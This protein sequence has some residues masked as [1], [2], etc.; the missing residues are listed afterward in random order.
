MVRGIRGEAVQV[1][2]PGEG[3]LLRGQGR[4]IQ[5]LVGKVEARRIMNGRQ[6]EPRCKELVARF[7]GP[8]PVVVS[9]RRRQV[10]GVERQI[11]KC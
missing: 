3:V 11:E 8:S 2:Q 5:G 10:Y 7:G 4:S 6:P 1:I 9:M